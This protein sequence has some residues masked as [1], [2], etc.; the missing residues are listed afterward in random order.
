MGPRILGVSP[1][2]WVYEDC[3]VIDWRVL[4]LGAVL[5]SFVE[6][7]TEVDCEV[8]FRGLGVRIE[9]DVSVGVEYFLIL[10]CNIVSNWGNVR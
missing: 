6:S 7:C 3:C 8:V 9:A 4:E 1:I 2:V 10:A 5:G